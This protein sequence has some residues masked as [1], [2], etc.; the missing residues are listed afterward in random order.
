[1]SAK[2]A[3]SVGAPGSVRPASTGPELE[4]RLERNLTDKEK[5]V[6]QNLRHEADLAPNSDIGMFMKYI[7]A[8]EG[9]KLPAL[10]QSGLSIEQ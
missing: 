10:P 2:R 5:G 3:T 9:E 7:D 6:L 8:L 1:M 4:L